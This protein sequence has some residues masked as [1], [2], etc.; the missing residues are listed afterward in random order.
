[1]KTIA[2]V[3]TSQLWAVLVVSKNVR[4]QT[5]LPR[6]TRLAR[7]LGA[8]TESVLVSESRPSDTSAV[9]VA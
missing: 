8:I 4:L 9:R 5:R 6:I 7:R 2:T 1:M 3:T